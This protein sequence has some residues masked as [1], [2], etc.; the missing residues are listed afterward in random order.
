MKLYERIKNFHD[1]IEFSTTYLN[2]ILGIKEDFNE[3]N[4]NFPVMGNMGKMNK[5]GNDYY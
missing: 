1:E 3:M 2:R 4:M 5:M